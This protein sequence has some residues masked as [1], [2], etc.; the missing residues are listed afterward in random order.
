MAPL[1]HLQAKL[2]VCRTSSLENMQVFYGRLSECEPGRHTW[3]PQPLAICRL[4]C[5]VRFVSCLQF[6]LSV[7]WR[8][9]KNWALVG[10]IDNEKCFQIFNS[11]LYIVLA[12]HLTA[13]TQQKSRRS[14]MIFGIP[15]HVT[16]TVRSL[17][18]SELH[19]MV[20]MHSCIYC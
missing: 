4:L 17:W 14:Q 13:D 10:S 12:T 1:A 5:V 3:A 18:S 20:F 19:R 2:T 9:N 16:C 15:F 7:F 8:E 11:W 6:L